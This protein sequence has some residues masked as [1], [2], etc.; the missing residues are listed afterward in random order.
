VRRHLKI[1][2][3]TETFPPEVNGVAMTI[4]VMVRGMLARGHSVEVMR[5]AQLSDQYPRTCTTHPEILSRGIAIPGYASMQMGLPAP[6][7][8][9][10]RWRAVRPDVVQLVTEGPLGFSAMLVARRLGIPVVSE[11]HTNFNAYARHYGKSW[12]TRPVAAYLKYL[13]NATAVTLA[14]TDEIAETLRSSGYARVE[15]VSRGV[16]TSL[17][18]PGRRSEALR[19]IWGARDDDPIVLHVGRLAPEKNLD[20]LFEAFDSIRAV[21]PRAK[22][23]MVGDGPERTRLAKQYRGHFFAGIQRGQSLAAHYASAD[24]FLYPSLTETFGNVT[25]E[26]MASGLSVVAFNYAA[27]RDHIR[28]EV[29]GL[30]ARFG[31]HGEFKSLAADLACDPV[32]ISRL[33][34]AARAAAIRVDWDKVIDALEQVLLT[35]ASRERTAKLRRRRL[36]PGTAS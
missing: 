11:Y 32:R 34:R 15:V 30:L 13:H 36:T 8:L 4:D 5:P 27:A 25:L 7:L 12:L 33:G 21:A 3:V 23:V 26:A 9:A 6:R 22:L 35:S 20:L 24:V 1:A 2:V 10:Q 29:N 31:D 28:T 14:P 19:R 17:F 18:D 16:D